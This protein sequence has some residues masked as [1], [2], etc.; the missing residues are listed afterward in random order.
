MG[1]SLLENN[2]FTLLSSFY[3][4]PYLLSSFILMYFILSRFSFMCFSS[5]LSLHFLL[6]ISPLHASLFL[7]PLHQTQINSLTYQ[8]HPNQ[9]TKLVLFLPFEYRHYNVVSALCFSFFLWIQTLHWSVYF[10]IQ[11][12]PLS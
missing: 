9:K 11:F 8:H 2:Y 5:L 6:F 3:S 12:L 4:I 1:L 7:S 10:L